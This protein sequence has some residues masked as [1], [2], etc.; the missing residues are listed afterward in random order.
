MSPLPGTGPSPGASCARRTAGTL[1]PRST[2][3]R[4]RLPPQLAGCVG[5][6][7]NDRALALAVMA[8]SATRPTGAPSR[9]TGAGCPPTGRLSLVRQAI[10]VV[11]P[12]CRDLHVPLAHEK[13]DFTKKQSKDNG[14]K[15]KLA[16]TQDTDDAA[17][18]G[19]RFGL[20]ARRCRADP[21]ASSLH[22]DDRRGEHRFSAWRRHTTRLGRPQR[23]GPGRPP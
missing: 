19:H 9:W 12:L 6:D 11:I 1:S 10:A 13:L 21:G 15:Q 22:I 4:Q 20:P 8:G 16:V 5:L 7:L 14:K 2:C 18:P 23:A 17:R 3:N